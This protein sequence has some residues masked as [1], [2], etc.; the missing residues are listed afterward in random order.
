MLI[1]T[2][3]NAPAPPAGAALAVVGLVLVLGL[4][5]PREEGGDGLEGHAFAQL[6]GRVF[7]GL[8]LVEGLLLDHVLV[9]EAVEELAQQT[10]GGGVSFSFSS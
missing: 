1:Q 6:L 10:W 3:L 9:V 4:A 2:G 5:E 8:P 7:A